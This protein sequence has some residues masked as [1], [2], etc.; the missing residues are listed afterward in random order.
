[1]F[2]HLLVGVAA[3]TLWAC[4]PPAGELVPPQLL[5]VDASYACDDTAPD[6]PNQCVFW[7]TSDGKV[8]YG[9]VSMVQLPP[10]GTDTIIP[11]PIVELGTSRVD[12]GWKP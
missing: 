1:M 3:L 5:R 4:A 7:R 6:G 12:G 11:P 9:P 8:Y 2:R 10:A